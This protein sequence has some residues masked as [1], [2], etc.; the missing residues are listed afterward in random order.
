MPKNKL[1]DIHG[2]FQ[3]SPLS[4]QSSVTDRNDTDDSEVQAAYRLVT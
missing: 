2:G 1:N 4:A 3:L